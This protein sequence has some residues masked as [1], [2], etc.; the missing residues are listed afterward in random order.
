MGLVDVGVFCI[1]IIELRL[2]VLVLLTCIYF[3]NVTF[4]VCYI[5]QQ[6]R[7]HSVKIQGWERQDFLSV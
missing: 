7:M 4:G 2:Y 6:G 5:A 1:S 3:G